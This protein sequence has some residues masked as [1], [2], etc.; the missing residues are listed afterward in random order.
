MTALLCP[1]C[2]AA[3]FTAPD[4]TAD[5]PALAVPIDDHPWSARLLNFFRNRQEY[6]GG[7]QYVPRPIETFG[8][9]CRFSP[10]E[11]IMQPNM[12]KVSLAEVRRVLTERG[13]HLAGDKSW[14]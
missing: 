8:D 3:L 9:L 11:F 6:C 1:H 4:V 12:G 14:R 10:R 5:N 13:L 2:G 7:G